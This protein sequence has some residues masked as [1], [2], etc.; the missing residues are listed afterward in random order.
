MAQDDGIA[1]ET[2]YPT[3]ESPTANVEFAPTRNGFVGGFPLRGYLGS[4]ATAAGYGEEAPWLGA[5]QQRLVNLEALILKL[6][7]PGA[8]ETETSLPISGGETLEREATRHA[9]S[10]TGLDA[11]SEADVSR[12]GELQ[13]RALIAEQNLAA[14]RTRHRAAEARLQRRIA[15]IQRSS[16]E[17]EQRRIDAEARCEEL[18][19]ASTKSLLQSVSLNS[20][21]LADSAEKDSAEKQL[22]GDSRVAAAEARAAALEAQVTEL[23]RRLFR[24]GTAA[25]SASSPGVSAADLEAAMARASNAEARS[26]AAEARAARLEVSAGDV[27]AANMRAAQAETRSL[28]AER[29]AALLQEELSELRQNIFRNRSAGELVSVN[30][31]AAFSTTGAGRCTGSGEYRAVDHFFSV[32]QRNAIEPGNVQDSPVLVPECEPLCEPL[33]P[34]FVSPSARGREPYRSAMA[35]DSSPAP[36]P[37][38]R[39]AQHRSGP[40]PA[41]SPRLA[42]PNRAVARG[43]TGPGAKGLIAPNS[44]GGSTSAPSL[45]AAGGTAAASARGGARRMASGGGGSAVA[46]SGPSRVPA[47]NVASRRAE[48]P[49]VATRAVMHRADSPGLGPRTAER[50][51][52]GGQN[53][54]LLKGASAARPKSPGRPESPPRPNSPPKTT[55]VSRQTSG[56]SLRRAR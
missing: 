3:C 5:A 37:T 9:P 18:M 54:S 15:D 39:P 48:S 50:R 52:S 51:T 28:A 56:P 11:L 41:A 14:E 4:G 1:E 53:A 43:P 19:A 38:P 10:D 34:R 29:R 12:F 24:E 42:S 20:D 25:L 32:A 13:H 16:E 33:A 27:E 26:A 49:A 21:N 6:Q 36:S 35:P 47:T 55:I 23:W 2:P 17:E 46:P 31:T 22:V 7:R 30:G 45:A 8:P 40:K 44:R